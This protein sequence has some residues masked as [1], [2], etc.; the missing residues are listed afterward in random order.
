MNAYVVLLKGIN[1]GG[2]N[3]LPM[4]PL[5][6]LLEKAGYLNVRTY[7]QSGNIVLD[8]AVNPD[9]ELGSLIKDSFGFEP[10]VM[11][12]TRDEFTAATDANPFSGAGN[13]I[14]FYFCQNTPQLDQPLLDALLGPSESY[15]VA[16][17]VFYLHAPDGIGRSKLVAKIESCLGVAATGRNLNTVNKLQLM[18]DAS[19]Q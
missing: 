8:A 19:P 2:K 6:E 14:H 3:P 4:K 13:T 12:L 5:K 1:V 18:L 7:I 15:E 10:D 9:G 17:D 16:G 11:L